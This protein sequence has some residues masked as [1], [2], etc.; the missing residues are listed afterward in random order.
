MIQTI[1]PIEAC[2]TALDLFGAMIMLVIAITH[3]RRKTNH[4]RRSDRVLSYLIM[5][6]LVAIIA[7]A[8]TWYFL[9]VSA[10]SMLFRV[11]LIIDYTF[12]QAT[13][14]LF[15]A[16]I[17]EMLESKIKGPRHLYYMAVMCSVI[18][19]LFWIASYW[20]G[21]FYMFG[22]HG[23][24]HGKYHIYSQLP[25]IIFILFDVWILILSK[26]KIPRKDA[27]TWFC[28]GIIASCAIFVGA[29]VKFVILYVT[30]TV[31]IVLVYLQIDM[32]RDIIFARQEAEL[33]KMRVQIA[34]SKTRVVMS[35]I[36]PHFLYNSISAIMG[37]EG[38]PKET[39]KAL[40][41]FGKYLRGNLEAL[42]HEEL[43]PFSKEMEHVKLYTSLEMLRFDDVFVE[44]DIQIEEFE[45][46]P[47]TIQIL[48]ENAI[49]H[50][51]SGKVGGGNVT[52]R[53]FEREDGYCIQVEDDGIGFVKED[54]YEEQD[55]IRI[56]SDGGC[57]IGLKNVELRLELVQ[58]KLDI[59]SE[60]EVGTTVSIWL[61]KNVKRG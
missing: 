21:W 28:Y 23:Y 16:Y 1:T 32:Q 58:G 13:L 50:G 54:L 10:E 37:I 5:C 19:V 2:N 49:K 27:I 39:K 24:V 33:S 30:V 53:T 14:V 43:I 41:D 35:Q 42:D 12:M 61:P 45:V 47:L 34:D 57:H 25:V 60:K 56:W 46:P 51:V 48:V 11:C 26:N 44:Y 7:D 59:T 38:N 18:L 52:I 6:Y 8:G 17:L 31:L 22:E 20:T 15:H 40:L 29:F 9:S 3:I 36:K 55:G 4:R